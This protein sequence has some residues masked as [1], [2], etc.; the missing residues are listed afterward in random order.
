MAQ[1]IRFS[2][3][4]SEDL[5]W[6]DITWSGSINT[7]AANYAG[8]QEE[9]SFTPD[10]Y[11]IFSVQIGKIN[12][13][14]N[15]DYNIHKHLQVEI[16]SSNSAITSYEIL[17]PTGNLNDTKDRKALNSAFYALN[18]DKVDNT[19]VGTNPGDLVKLGSNRQWWIN[20]IPGGTNEDKFILDND[21]SAPNDI[22]LQFGRSLNKVLK[23]DTLNNRFDF[24]ANA[25]IQWILS[26]DGNKISLNASGT[27]DLDVFIVA[28][29]NT[30]SGGTIK[31][32][33]TSQAWELSSTGSTFAEIASIS[34]PQ[35]FTNKVIDANKNQ[36]LNLP[37]NS[38]VPKIIQLVPEYPGATLF[39]DGTNNSWTMFADYEDNGGLNK[40][41]YYA[42]TSRKTV[43]QD[44]DLAIRLQL[45]KPFSSFATNPI[46]F[47]YKTLS[48]DVAKNKIDLSIENWSG[49]TVALMGNTDLVSS[50]DNTWSNTSINF[51]GSPTFNEG[52]W[53]T[54]KIKLSSTDL[55][56]AYAGELILNYEGL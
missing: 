48:S 35:E 28:N 37:G 2:L 3:W 45:P 29:Q 4:S 31:Y 43:I 16:K 8:W 50:S 26:L 52:E 47:N 14:P 5:D 56:T 21:D 10:S 46:S 15:I 12:P 19:D 24:N 17:D 27:N 18:A 6:N 42:W 55:W 22:V 49:A 39:G 53:I 25:L 30:G 23:F 20:F 41:N 36:I 38:P 51:I 9:Q 40:H 11:G 7:A 54:I 33:A 44:Y 32:N 13:L 1:T 34:T